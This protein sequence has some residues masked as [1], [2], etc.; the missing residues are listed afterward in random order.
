MQPA[1][2]RASDIYSAERPRRLP[3]E[4]PTIGA[5]TPVTHLWRVE[6]SDGSTIDVPLPAQRGTY[7][8]SLLKI[9]DEGEVGA[10]TIA[11]AVR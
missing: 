3:T 6:R 2:S 4:P 11:V 10:A 5:A 1:G 7:V 9:D 8:I